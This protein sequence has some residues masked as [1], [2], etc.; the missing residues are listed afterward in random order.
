MNRLTGWLL[1][2]FVCV[3]SVCAAAQG[4]PS[5]PVKLIVP[6][7]PGGNNDIIARIF[8]QKLSERFG[9]PIVID[10]RGGAAG[11]IGAAA[12]AKAPPDGYTLVI[13]DLG[14]LVIATFAD[15]NL[16]Y[17]PANDFAPIGVIAS[18]SIVVTAN[19][20]FLVNTFDEFL[21]QARARPGKLTYA[22]AGV[23]SPGHLA[24]ELLRSM[25][26][27]DLVHVP[28]KGGG[29]AIIDV[30]AGRVD[31]L[32]DGAA[33]SHLKSG[34]L[35]VLAVTGSRLPALPDV[36]SIGESVRGF[37]FTN[38]WGILA[39]AGT[40]PDVV[41]RVNKEL[42]QIAALA[43]IRER[44]SSLGLMAQSSTP[45]EF[46]DLLRSEHE[47]VGRIVKEADIKFE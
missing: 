22:T 17:H 6:Y 35:K 31:V 1:A 46:A 34:K 10:N 47:K 25:A 8:A 9:Q 20:D 23:G 7:P 14:N 11:R 3:W 15:P 33:F 44:L 5:R 13:G 2:L 40:P 38:W 24:F 42:V 29:P 12:A 28:Y 30:A 41:A 16:Q 32:V 18:V 27:I 45:Q 21:V 43:E 36:P 39:P 4:Y 19:L 37:V 26:K